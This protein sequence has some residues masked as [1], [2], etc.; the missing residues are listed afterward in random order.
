MKIA[1]E[2][3]IPEYDWVDA[4]TL[5]QT[6]LGEFSD[7]DH[8]DQIG[9]MIDHLQHMPEIEIKWIIE[10]N[11]ARIR[12]RFCKQMVAEHLGFVEP[13]Q[14][15]WVAEKLS[16]FLARFQ[17]RTGYEFSEYKYDPKVIS[18]GKKIQF[19]TFTKL[20]DDEKSAIHYAMILRL[21]YGSIEYEVKS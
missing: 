4:P 9:W 12:H 5:Y 7:K 8:V 18:S 17:A 21:Q 14:I 15:T 11:H 6:P 1:V 20:F 2:F 16:H 10:A 3:E 19:K 13:D